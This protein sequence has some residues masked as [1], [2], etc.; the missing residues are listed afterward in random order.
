MLEERIKELENE[1]AKLRSELDA[2]DPSFFEEIEDLKHD[3]YLL[4]QKVHQ[5]EEIIA[6]METPFS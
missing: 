6:Q 1:N 4:T 3:H 5:Y 2:F